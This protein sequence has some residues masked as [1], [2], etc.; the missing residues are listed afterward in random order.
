MTTL[1]QRFQC[2]LLHIHQYTVRIL[3][4]PGS[5]LYTANW[6]SRDN[7]T[8]GKDDEITGMNLNIN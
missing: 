2:N 6:L 7:H 8:E 3:S 4:M 1:S 5:Q